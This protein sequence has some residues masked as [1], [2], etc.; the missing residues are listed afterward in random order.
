MLNIDFW[1]KECR[2]SN[3][4]SKVKHRIKVKYLRALLLNQSMLNIKF[5][6][7]KYRTS[8]F[9]PDIKHIIFGKRI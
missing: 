5:E 9:E 3:F 1:V 4:G 8:I 7:W 6:V 2:T